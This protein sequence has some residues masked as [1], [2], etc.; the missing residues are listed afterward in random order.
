[1]NKVKKKFFGE[2][3]LKNIKNNLFSN[4]HAWKKIEKFFP[5]EYH[6]KY[7][8]NFLLTCFHEKKIQTIFFSLVLMK[9]K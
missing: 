4:E 3:S 5:D 9:K 7:L 2:F 1:M 6:E 8:G